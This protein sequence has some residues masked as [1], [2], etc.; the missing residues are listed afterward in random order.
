MDKVDAAIEKIE[1]P[2]DNAWFDIAL[3]ANPARMARVTVPADV[4]DLELLAL[5]A[6]VLG[7]GDRLRAQRKSSGILVPAHVNRERQDA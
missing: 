6:N 3:M 1:A 7:I 2:A 5:I 4:S